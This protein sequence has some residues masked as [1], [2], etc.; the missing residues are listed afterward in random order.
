MSNNRVTTKGTIE[1]K[2]MEFWAYH[3]HFEEE[4]VIGNRFLL[5]VSVEYDISKAGS[6]DLLE[7]TLNYQELYNI[8]KREMAI[9]SYLLER[10]ASRVV[11][12]IFE[13]FPKVESVSLEIAKLNPPL[14][15]KLHSSKVTLK[16]SFK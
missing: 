5:S 7:D 8:I 9:T 15:G 1:L 10:V 14:G 3:G 11:D 13:A 2:E 6:S 12:S 4:Q 16:R